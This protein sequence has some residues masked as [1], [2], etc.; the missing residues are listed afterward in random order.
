MMFKILNDLA[1]NRLR[2]VFRESHSTTCNYALRNFT[3]IHGNG[4]FAQYDLSEL[5]SYVYFAV[6]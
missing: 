3:T 4:L 5:K 6:V 1:P 2:K